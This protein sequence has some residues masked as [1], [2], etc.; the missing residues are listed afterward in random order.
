[1]AVLWTGL[2]LSAI[3]DSF[4]GIALMWIGVRAVGSA[5]GL[6]AAA[7]HAATLVFGLF[8]GVLA[9]RWD[10][11]RT[12]IGADLARAAAVVTLPLGAWLA[13]GD[14]VVRL[15]HLV[16]VAVVLGVFT[17]LFTPA[18]QASLPVL[19]EGPDDL[20]AANALVDV[21]ARIARAVAP[22]LAG[23]LAARIALTHFFTLDA[24]SFMISALAVFSLGARFAWRAPRAEGTAHAGPRSLAR[25]LAAAFAYV[26]ESAPVSWT[27][28]A[29]FGVNFAWASA[30][31]VGAPL[32]AD[33]V[34]RSDVG[35]YG[36][37]VAAYGLGNIASNVVLGST[38]L[39]K[40]LTL[41]FLGKAVLGLGFFVLS[42][43][44]N[45]PVAMAGA[46]IAAVGGPMGDLSVLAMLQGDAPPEHLGK[47][48][49]LRIVTESGG[50]ALGLV[51]A[52][53]LFEVVPVRVGI[54]LA[55]AAHVAI[56]AAGLV[57]FRAAPARA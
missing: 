56:A 49:A 41:L 53:P 6:V 10:R 36:F 40:P 22:G 29:L 54:A 48:V 7:Q 35:A 51:V 46:A 17:V 43:A 30:F 18:L 1:V 13:G 52:T 55:A 5:V 57:R 20:H 44:P 42:V 3:G 16:A 4:Y 28:V 37:I 23:V 21:T 12:M 34:L 2:L 50:F 26:R 24:V 19:T 9:D 31:A 33:R 38:R 45:L 11:R 32:F 14:D 27:M 47:L 15:P 39:G 25:E 8:G